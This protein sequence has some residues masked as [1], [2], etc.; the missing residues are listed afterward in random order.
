MNNISNFE[1]TLTHLSAV[2]E[3]IYGIVQ[4]A[5][6]SIL[7]EETVDLASFSVS[8]L[9]SQCQ[10]TLESGLNYSLDRVGVERVVRFLVTGN[11]GV[12]APCFKWRLSGLI[13]ESLKSTYD[14]VT[15]FGK[16]TMVAYS[17]EQGVTAVVRDLP[18]AP[19]RLTKMITPF[20]T[21]ASAPVI[22]SPPITV[23]K[24]FPTKESW[25]EKV[26]F[27]VEYIAGCIDEAEATAKA[28]ADA[29]RETVR[30]AFRVAAAKAAATTLERA[31]AAKAK[32]EYEAACKDAQAFVSYG[33][34]H[35]KR[36]EDLKA[37]AFDCMMHL[38]QFGLV[39]TPSQVQDAIDLYN[40][41]ERVSGQM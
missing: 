2:A 26:S 17:P 9:A 18:G 6:S 32:T 16:I 39:F 30:D 40:L 28:A 3:T 24:E 36:Q 13:Q 11:D 27:S 19:S 15:P 7:R 41:V 37:V 31:A 14:K 29:A 34:S 12:F 4:S 35:K 20:L 1:W 22:Q 10:Q 5:C 38:G 25:I 8:G 21:N 23:V 33:K